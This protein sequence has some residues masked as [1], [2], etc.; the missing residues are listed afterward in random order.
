MQDAF[1]SRSRSQVSCCGATAHGAR[2]AAK[3][4]DLLTERLGQSK[5]TVDKSQKEFKDAMEKIRA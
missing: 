4:K 2:P 3:P 5:S 1:R